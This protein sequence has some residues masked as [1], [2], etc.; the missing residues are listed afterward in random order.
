LEV[1][2]K[3]C[4]NNSRKIIHDIRTTHADKQ[5]GIPSEIL[6]TFASDNAH[7]SQLDDQVQPKK[8]KK[9]RKKEKPTDRDLALVT[10][11]GLDRGSLI[12]DTIRTRILLNSRQ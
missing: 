1:N 10:A 3:K 6:P 11:Q 5:A 9:E 2:Q 7:S 8:K 12:L 4:I